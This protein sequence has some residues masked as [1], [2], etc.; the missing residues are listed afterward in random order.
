MYNN[1]DLCI[2]FINCVYVIAPFKIGNFTDKTKGQLQLLFKCVSWSFRQK[3]INFNDRV[4]KSVKSSSLDMY[5]NTFVPKRNINF[6]LGKDHRWRTSI[7]TSITWLYSLLTLKLWHR[8]SLRHCV[9]VFNLEWLGQL[10]GLHQSVL[11]LP[12]YK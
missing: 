3:V 12:P 9:Y 6:I 10:L 7:S 1:I 5:M 2:I 8:T 4:L 11:R